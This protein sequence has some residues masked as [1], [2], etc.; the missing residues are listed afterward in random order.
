MN[1]I[2]TIILFTLSITLLLSC[3]QTNKKI[4][5]DKS[6]SDTQLYY[7]GKIITME[8]EENPYAEVLVEQD[9]IIVFVG[10]LK[11]AE[12]L[13]SN[14]TKVDLK[15]ATLLPGFIDP[16]S[17]FGMV[18]NSMGQINLNPPPVGNTSS[19]N[20]LLDALKKYKTE[21]NIKDGEWIF[22]WGYDESQLVEK[23]H[24]N[25]TE[26]DAILPNNPVYLQH[27]SGHM[28]V[29]NSMALIKM[30]ITNATTN[31][32]GGN[33]DRFP[34]SNE[35]SG[36]I[37]ETAM[38]PFVGNMLEILSKKQAEY[39]DQTQNYYAENGITTAQDGMTD[40][41]TIQFFQ[42]QADN[43]KLKI[44]V[45]AL[46]GYMD[47]EK[48][49]TDTAMQ[50]KSYK[51]GFKIQGT[52]IVADGSPQGKTAFFTKT[53]LTPVSG[54][55]NDCRG[56][57]SLSQDAMNTLFKTAYAQN[58]QLFIHCNGDAAID[59]AIAAHEYACKELSQP[60]DK[61]RRTIIIHS[62]FARADQLETYKKYKIEPSFFTNHAYFWGDVHVDNLGKERADFLSPIATAAN[63]GLMYTN[64]SDATV[65]PI[66]PM[67]TVWSAVNRTSRTGQ[68]IG[69][70]EKATVYQALKA[71]TINAAYQYFEENSK[72]SLKKD[73]VAD[74]VILDKDPLTVNPM[75]LKNIKVIETI[76]S[77]K[78]IFSAMEEEEIINKYW[79]LITLDGQPV[80]M[81]ADQEKEQYFI[82][83][84]DNTINGF[85]GCNYFN[86]TYEL[87]ELNRIRFNEN[88]AVTKKYCADENI[89]EYDFLEVFML[90][91]NYIITGDTLSL[92]VGRSAPLAVFEAVYF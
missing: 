76:K 32:E 17:H 19:I 41:N 8:S 45:I 31:P 25:K 90:A 68:V 42:Q 50:F 1:I 33:I 15:G 35:P 29:A 77:G 82:L 7:N 52:K 80:L 62:Q 10:N 69:D 56:L 70:K 57:P 18:S 51:N 28:G 9:G 37:Q 84:S 58:N 78:I 21:N 71:I 4:S 20:E 3:G 72:G 75:E 53:Y 36:L 43:G 16:H 92:N 91:D 39:F 79:K 48:N 86:G 63:M 85:A 55:T 54:C 88:M 89:K 49:L 27:T 40:R 13:F 47:L 60:L 64:H 6:T 61:E 14:Y 66:N 24:P 44:D 46:A 2:K 5:N 65:T 73:K 81:T 59:M 67:F 83:K 23:R 87:Q 74:F 30:N 38:Y 11:E 22:G 26:L 34:N 12:K